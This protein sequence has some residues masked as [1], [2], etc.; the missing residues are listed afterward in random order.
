MKKKRN[1]R[2]SRK[3]KPVFIVFCE[4]ET[5]ETYVHFLGKQ[6][7]LPVKAHVTGLALSQK[8]IKKDIGAEK[9]V[10]MTK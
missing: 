2:P 6:Y 7:K 1:Q 8:K 9:L 3:M 4:G 5:E 10:V